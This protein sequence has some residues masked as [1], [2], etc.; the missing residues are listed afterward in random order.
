MTS[1]FR[2]IDQH[3]G[4]CA[5]ST[6]AS[7]ARAESKVGKVPLQHGGARGGVKEDRCALRPHAW[8]LGRL[9]VAQQLQPLLDI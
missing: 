6:D 7:R 1:W 2:T 3:S 5:D 4:G 8:L 9:K